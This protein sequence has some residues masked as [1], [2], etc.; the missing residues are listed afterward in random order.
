MA[1]EEVVVALEE[2]DS[3]DGVVGD[4]EDGAGDLEAEEGDFE[5][6]M[7]AGEAILVVAVVVVDSE[8]DLEGASEAAEGDFRTR[9]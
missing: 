4:M 1:S 6:A 7:E 3:E 2:V 8:G 5:G 9:L